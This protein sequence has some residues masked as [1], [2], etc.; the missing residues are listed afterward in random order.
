[1]AEH[2]GADRVETFEPTMVADLSYLAAA[3]A[4]ADAS[5]GSLDGYLRDGLGLDGDALAAVRDRLRA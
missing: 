5:F 2:L 4:Q 3:Y 1:M